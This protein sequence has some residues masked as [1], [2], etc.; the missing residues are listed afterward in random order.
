MK[1]ILLGGELHY[2]DAPGT[3]EFSDD[4]GI[5]L[6]PN[7]EVAGRMSLYLADDDVVREVE[8]RGLTV[9]FTQW[10]P[11]LEDRLAVVAYEIA[12]LVRD[13]GLDMHD[14]KK[15]VELAYWGLEY[16]GGEKSELAG[17]LD[18]IDHLLGGP[19]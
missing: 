11:T 10:E 13:E 1:M 17:A 2:A 12:G 18:R 6:T 7:R 16:H 5:G 3:P 8:L 9:T 19:E 14:F 15:I 4:G